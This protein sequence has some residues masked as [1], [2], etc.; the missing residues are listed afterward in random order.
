MEPMI[1]INKHICIDF[2]NN[3]VR[4]LDSGLVFQLGVNE[5]KLLKYFI[6]H[7]D[8]IL[9]RQLLIQKVWESKGIIVE[10]GSLM[11]SISLCR[12]ALQ[13]LRGKII[14]T[15]RGKGYRFSAEYEIQTQTANIPPAAQEKHNKKSNSLA[16]LALL[17]SAPCAFWGYGMFHSP[18]SVLPE[19]LTSS[20][21]SVCR[22]SIDGQ[23]V[24]ELNQGTR[25]QMDL[26]TVIVADDNTS[27]SV[28]NTYQ[29]VECYE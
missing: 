17:L 28:P 5:L 13:D 19:G 21:F 11:Q 10:D 20:Q 7:R 16:A 29:E 22:I 4:H 25:Y 9:E 1:I 6:E 18:L 14:V 24:Y 15:E 23:L 12:K 2:N 26:F 3:E 8:E 27:V